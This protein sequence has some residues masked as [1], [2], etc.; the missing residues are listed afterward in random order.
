MGLAPAATSGSDPGTLGDLNLMS[1]SLMARAGVAA[2]PAHLL[3]DDSRS[4]AGLPARDNLP[5]SG[6]LQLAR[7]RRAGGRR[8]DAS[9][10]KR[11]KAAGHSGKERPRWRGVFQCASADNGRAFHE[12]PHS[13]CTERGRCGQS[14]PLAQARDGA[15]RGGATAASRERAGRRRRDPPDAAAPAGAAPAGAG[16]PSPAQD[17]GETRTAVASL[18]PGA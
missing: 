3:T 8:A 14:S 6:G 12:W 13:R 4:W 5:E 11:G 2:R 18:V 1:V 10:G 7:P 16:A 17:D 9:Q 15:T